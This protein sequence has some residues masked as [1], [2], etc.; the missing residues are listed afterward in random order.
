MGTKR[1]NLEKDIS[2]KER[3]TGEQQNSMLLLFATYAMLI[4]TAWGA[5]GQKW[6]VVLS[7]VAWGVGDAFAALIGKPFGKHKIW[8]KGIDG[9]KSV[10]G[11]LAMFI[12]S[13]I[14][15]FLMYLH[16]SILS[17]NWLVALVSFWVAL[18][19]CI[20]ELFSKNGWDTFFCPTMAMMA[21]MILTFAAGGI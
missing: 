8:I 12:T 14:A 7:V 6:M 15:T 20:A 3:K 19:A 11:T 13:F 21:L 1:T 18:F 10:E 17:N 5:L 2:M 16:H 4:C 9:K